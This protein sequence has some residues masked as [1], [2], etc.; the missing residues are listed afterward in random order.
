MRVPQWGIMKHESPAR[1]ATAN[2]NAVMS[3]YAT[4]KLEAKFFHIW[5]FA[6]KANF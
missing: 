3:A 5:G 4:G 1:S 6:I 2:A